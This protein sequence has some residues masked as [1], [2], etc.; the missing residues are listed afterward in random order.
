MDAFRPKFTNLVQLLE[1][2]ID[3][4]G[5][6]PLF[7][8]YK[9]NNFW[10]WT[11]YAEFGK[12]VLKFRRAL[13]DIGVGAGDRV[14]VISNNRLEWAVG[15][16]ATYGLR[17]A[18]VPMYESQLE[19]EWKHII[20]DSRAKVC[21]VSTDRIRK[22]VEGFRAD[23][24]TLE[25]VVSFEGQGP[26]S[27]KHLI[28]SGARD[29]LV[30]MRPDE[31]DLASLIYTSGTTGTPKGVNLTHFN[32][33]ANVSAILELGLIAAGE[34]T[35]SFL[36]WAHVFGGCIEVHSC[37]ATGS[38]LAICDDTSKLL[39]YLPQVR[40]TVLF[41]VPRIW[42]RVYDSVNKQIAARPTIVRLVFRTAMAARSKE[43]M[44]TPLTPR[45]KLVLG[46]AEKVVFSKIR[47]RFGG[48]LKLALSGAAALS[49]DVAEFID[50]LGIAVYEGYGL[51]ECSGGA[52]VNRPG[53]RRLGSVGQV[54]PGFSIRLDKDATG[55]ASEEG[56]IVV[57]GTGV[58]A[59]YENLPELSRD[60]L[61][62]DGGLRTGDLGRVDADGFVYITGRVKELYKLSNGKYVAPAPL[63]EG[64]QLSP[65]IAQCV[66]YGEDEP[67]NVAM[68]VPDA[69]ALEGW[70][71]SHGVKGDVL[72]DPRIRKLI[73]SEIDKLSAD[74]KGYERIKDFFFER[75]PMTTENGLLTPTLKLKRRVVVAR[76]RERFRA[77]YGR[78][79][80]LDA[81]A[82]S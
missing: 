5:K 71:K 51:T 23:V 39:D 17:A 59:G 40:P 6:K 13:S 54:A 7:G 27:Y 48:R 50:N 8:T 14:A 9:G 35:L 29:P 36:P 46:L 67:Y 44:G 31:G 34:R 66:V 58:M 12:A 3:R 49:K 72:Q 75:E 53:A 24:A 28:A 81:H 78:T 80:V 30:A 45:E 47:G 63:E 73:A 56:E 77:L 4:H 42:N 52:T 79:G 20:A 69:A 18:Y 55:A 15:A 37:M 64:L 32:L 16:H 68:I 70:A 26:G 60:V 10:S 43:K 33:A 74:F 21:L 1:D 38:A 62:A 2:S 41:A 76:Y 19:K 11:S 25:H 22:V 57:Y 82:P 61:T 65:Y